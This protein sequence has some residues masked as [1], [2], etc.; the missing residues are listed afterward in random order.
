[1]PR[2]SSAIFAG[3]RARG[4]TGVNPT[5][6]ERCLAGFCGINHPLKIRWPITGGALGYSNCVAGSSAIALH[7]VTA[8]LFEELERS[9][10]RLKSRLMQAFQGLLACRVLLT[11]NDAPLLGQHQVLLGKATAGVLGRSVINLRLG[12]NCRNLTGGAHLLYIW[13]RKEF[14]DNLQPESLAVAPPS[15]SDYKP[16]QNELRNI[17]APKDA[18][19]EARANTR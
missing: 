6:L 4:R 14:S 11:R 18:V 9:L 1:M 12:A 10:L 8:L 3:T 7:K 13:P 2:G 15:F 16:P 5:R 19:L 17:Q